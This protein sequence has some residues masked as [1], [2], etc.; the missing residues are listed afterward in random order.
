MV[1]CELSVNQLQRLRRVLIDGVGRPDTITKLLEEV[2]HPE[3]LDALLDKLL[4]SD[5]INLWCC[6]RAI[7]IGKGD[8]SR[9]EDRLIS[10]T[11][12]RIKNKLTTPSSIVIIAKIKHMNVKKVQDAIITCDFL[13]YPEKIELLEDVTKI[14]GASIDKTMAWYAQIKGGI[15]VK[16][17]FI[18]I[19]NSI[20][21]INRS[22]KYRIKEPVATRPASREQIQ[23]LLNLIKVKT[24]QD[25]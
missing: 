19:N 22:Y 24:I 1:K 6:E 23:D 17:L 14:S 5:N 2:T 25:T 10:E 11:I 16:S 7:K 20:D 21:K 18:L 3:I 8:L 9:V 15:K 4:S 13:T 12:Y